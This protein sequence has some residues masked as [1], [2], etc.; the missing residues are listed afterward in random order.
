MR[1]FRELLKIVL[2]RSSFFQPKTQN[3]VWRL[4]CA[5]TCRGA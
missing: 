1:L 3:V 4:R 2:A 5:R